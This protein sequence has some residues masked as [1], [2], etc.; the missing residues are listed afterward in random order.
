MV[1]MEFYTMLLGAKLHIPI[2]HLNNTTN[3]TTPDFIICWLNYVEQ[4]NP[5]IHFVLGKVNVIADLLSWLDHLEESIL[6]KR[7]QVFILKQSV[8]KEMDFADDPLL[9]KCFLNLPH[10]PVQDT[11]PTNYQWIF[12]KKQN[13]WID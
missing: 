12:T 5:Y 13:R 10:L 9:I 2:D 6:S 8:S 3:K 7:E 1:L 11:N 4:C